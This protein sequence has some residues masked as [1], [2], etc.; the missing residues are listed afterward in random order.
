MNSTAL[1]PLFL[2][3][4]GRRCIVAGL[5]SVGCRK[6]AGLLAAGATDI[7]ALEKSGFGKLSAQAQGLLARQEVKL[8]H[9][10]FDEQDAQSGH[11][12]FAATSDR[13]ENLRIARLCRNG[14]ALCNC[15]TDPEAGDFQVP[16][17]ARKGK[18]TAALSTAGQSP[19]LARQWRG[20][21]E[22]WLA[23]REG[24]A[25]LL[26]RLREPLLALGLGQDANAAIFRS[27][28]ASAVAD[29]LA[30]DDLDKCRAWLTAELPCALAP[31]INDIFL[32]Y[33]HI[34]R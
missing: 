18:L 24:I 31:A 27:L 15:A 4:E 6:L 25:W 20:E 28:A 5:G 8:E 11:L 12:V 2:S 7:L 23:G 19:A 29:W 10:N 22:K 3:L 32:E 16:A 21:Q 14:G 30:E 1:Y 26:G 33:E 13:S 34:F 9:R 17:V